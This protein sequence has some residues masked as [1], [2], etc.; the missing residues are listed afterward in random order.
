M[1]AKANKQ[2]ITE[3]VKEGIKNEETSDNKALQSK[4]QRTQRKQ[5]WEFIAIRCYSENT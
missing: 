3:D 5:V 1:E 2:W 4:T